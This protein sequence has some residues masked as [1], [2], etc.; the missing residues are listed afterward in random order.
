MD[1]RRGIIR[2]F[3]SGTYLADVQIVGSMATMLTGVPVAKQIETDLLMSGSKCGVLFFDET[4]PCDACVLFIYGEAHPG[5]ITIPQ[6]K[7]FRPGGDANTA[8][9]EDAVGNA[10]LKDAN[11]GTKTLRGLGYWSITMSYPDSG[12]RTYNHPGTSYVV[13][14]AVYSMPVD[15]AGVKEARV[16]ATAQGNEAGSGK[17]ISIWNETDGQ[18]LC[19]VTWD[20]SARQ[21]ALAGSWT[22]VSASGE[23]TLRVRFKGWSA[24]EDITWWWVILQLR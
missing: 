6:G 18:M 2:A 9:G 8:F 15:L 10:Y 4:N 20:G 23:K 14:S 16:V 7:E 5:H 21:D 13:F 1:I 11:A 19:E 12:I 24:A 3:D 17:G 22:S